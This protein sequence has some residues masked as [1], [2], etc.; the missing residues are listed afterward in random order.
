MKKIVLF[1]IATVLCYVAIAQ[2]GDEFQT[3]FKN[4]KISSVRGFGGPSMS[5]STIDGQFVHFMGGGGAVILNDKFFFGGFGSGTTNLVNAKD[6]YTGTPEVNRYEDFRVEM[7]YGGF[8][9][10]YIFGG[11]NPIHPIIHLQT[12]WG[13][14]HL[15]EDVIDNN[16]F[17]FGYSGS[18]TTIY[19]SGIFVLNPVVEMEMNITKFLRLGIGANYRLVY[20]LDLN[21]YANND[22]AGPGGFLSFKFGWF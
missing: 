1:V 5:F 2:E 8:W 4:F 10:G 17:P 14:V 21:G 16:D 3:I 6:Y 13:N 22:F 18:S 15:S 11:K 7:D 20:G 9:L 19:S 12:G